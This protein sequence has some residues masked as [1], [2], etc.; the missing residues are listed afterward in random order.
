MTKKRGELTDKQKATR[1]DRRSDNVL[2]LESMRSAVRSLATLNSGGVVVMLGFMQAVLGKDVAVVFRPYG[3]GAL[4]CFAVGAIAASLTFL[5]LAQ[6]FKPTTSQEDSSGNEVGW[7]LSAAT[8]TA[9]LGFI[10]LIFG[11]RAAF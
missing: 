10:I 6:Y 4:I 3:L 9:I 7:L 8:V 11:V 5:P 1:D 2:H